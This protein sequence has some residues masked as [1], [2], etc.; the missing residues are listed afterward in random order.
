VSSQLWEFVA[1]AFVL[2][3]VTIIMLRLYLPTATKI[4]TLVSDTAGSLV[5]LT[6]ESL[7]GL[8][9]IQAFQHEEYFVKVYFLMSTLLC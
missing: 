1:F 8:E 5:G 3:V 2:M 7:E 9:V 6:A 4:K